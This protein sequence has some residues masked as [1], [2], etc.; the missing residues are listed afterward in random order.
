MSWALGTDCCSW[1]G[2]NCR[3]ENTVR[4]ISLPSK[5]LAGSI[6][7]SLSNLAKLLHLNLSHNSLSGGLPMDS[8]LF[9]SIAVL[10]V[11]FNHL[12]GPLQELQSSNP[13]LSLPLQVM[14]ISSNF[15]HRTI[16]IS[17]MGM[18][19][20][21]V[22]LNAS[23]NSFTGQIPASICISTPSFAV[24][25]LWSFG[26]TNSDAEFPQNGKI[27]NS[28]GQ[29]N[30]KNSIGQLRRLEEL[31]L[32]NNNMVGELPSALGNRTNLRFITLRG[33]R[34]TGDL[35]KVHSTMLDLKIPNFSMN[36]FTVTI[37]ES[38]YSSSNLIALW[39]AFNR[40]RGHISQ[41]IG[42]LNYPKVPLLP[43]NY[44]QLFYQYHKYTS[45]AQ[46]HAITSPI[47]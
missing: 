39:L 31:H 32:D 27:P 25:D 26:A 7:P 34:F 9:S 17:S 20:N 47:C 37:H 6:S 18:M 3:G 30:K 29:L 5:G 33:N 23:N 8:L 1:E 12:D 10:D 2:I 46:K 45:D 22:A 43:F 42:D 14:N 15:F 40:F 44:Q 13:S 35:G 19:K 4:D 41:R 21:L 11:S 28:I 38:I 36:N 24:L 16:S